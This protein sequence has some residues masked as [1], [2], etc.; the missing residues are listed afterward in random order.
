ME[1]VVVEKA[2]VWLKEDVC[3]SLVLCW[4]G[5]VLYEYA[6]LKLGCPN[7]SVTI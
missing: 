5:R 4:F 2:L 7:H 3:A 6:L 1:T